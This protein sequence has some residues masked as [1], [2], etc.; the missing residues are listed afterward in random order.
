MIKISE[1]G[2]TLEQ[3]KLL[4]EIQSLVVKMECIKNHR[5]THALIA[6]LKELSND[7]I[8]PNYLKE[9]LN[10]LFQF[11]LQWEYE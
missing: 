6:I 1:V 4:K 10:T 7:I 9:K 3:S 11:N 2:L 5:Q 8:D